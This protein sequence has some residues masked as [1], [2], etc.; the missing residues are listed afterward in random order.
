M[1]PFIQIRTIGRVF[2]NIHTVVSI[3]IVDI[4]QTD[5][6]DIQNGQVI[7]TNFIVLFIVAAGLNK[8]FGKNDN[9]RREDARMDKRHF[10]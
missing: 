2:R 1:V 5:G 10:V 6:V 9:V 8:V 3:N 7:N 4:G